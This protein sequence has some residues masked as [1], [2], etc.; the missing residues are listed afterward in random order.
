MRPR[1]AA[2]MNARDAATGPTSTRAPRTRMPA[3]VAEPGELSFLGL[4]VRRLND[5]KSRNRG[6]REKGRQKR[7]ARNP[8][9][10]SYDFRCH[11]YLTPPEFHNEQGCARIL[12]KSSY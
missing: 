8:I 10:V 6:S 12:S 3:L 5:N 4:N 11:V 9:F 7:A 2:T 1:P